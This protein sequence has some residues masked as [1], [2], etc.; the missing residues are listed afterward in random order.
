MPLSENRKLYMAEYRR[1][2]AE[3]L[4]EYNRKYISEWKV[5]LRRPR[6]NQ[7]GLC[8]Q[9]SNQSERRCYGCKLVKSIDSFHR[10]SS[11]PGGRMYLCKDCFRQY[12]KDRYSEKV[13]AR[14]RLREAVKNGSVIKYPCVVCGEKKS[15]GHHEDYSKPL[16]VVWLC[17][18]HHMERHRKKHIGG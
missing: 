5:G 1:K 3:R 12:Q 2:N 15:N 17:L 10:S 4:K 16:E 14:H 11:K 7:H 6:R 13:Y 9:V 8:N 18:K